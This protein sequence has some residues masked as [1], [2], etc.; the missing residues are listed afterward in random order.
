[1]LAVQCGDLVHTY[2]PL[3]REELHWWE[4]KG[5]TQDLLDRSTDAKV[6]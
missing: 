4:E 5:I 2:E 1:M 3:I 6:R